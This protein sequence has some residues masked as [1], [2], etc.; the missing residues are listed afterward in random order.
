MQDRMQSDSRLLGLAYK[1]VFGT[2][3][4]VFKFAS[5]AFKSR[6]RGH[7]I[8]DQIMTAFMDLRPKYLDAVKGN[9]AQVLGLKFTDPLVEATARKAVRNHAYSWVDFFRFA[10][11][12]PEQAL[13]LVQSVPSLS[14]LERVVAEG[15]GGILLTAHAGNY[16]L[17]GIL[18]RSKNLPVHAVYKP[19]RFE[20]VERLRSDMRAAGGVVGIP[21]DG[22]GFSTLPLVK[23]LR[24]GKL[25]G[26]QGDRDFSRNGVK[27]PFFGREAF[28][29]RGPWELAAM[30][31][32]PILCGLFF[33]DAEHGFHAI[34]AEPITIRSG[35]GERMKEIE[36]GMR[37]YVSMLEDFIR[38]HP[39]QWYCFYPFWDDPMREP[40]QADS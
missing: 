4:P 36:A 6:K 18:L 25:V 3:F 24:E 32:A 21:V 13:E 22:V 33:M 9:V 14:I 17:G 19:D 38:A 20:A 7:E 10:Q 34:F 5:R 29:P 12:P 39:D 35:R 26:M 27:I 8:A 28:F 15:K 1:V 16:E 11:R 30:T 23:V 2:L 31:G 37:R 40:A